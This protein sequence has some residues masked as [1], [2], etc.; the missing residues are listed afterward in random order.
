MQIIMPKEE[1]STADLQKEIKTEGDALMQQ[2]QGVK[3]DLQPYDSAA[4][5]QARLNSVTEQYGDI[6]TSV[7]S[8][9]SEGFVTMF[10]DILSGNKQASKSFKEV[11]KIFVET[12][13][14]FIAASLAQAVAAA[15]LKAM[16][17]GGNPIASLII[18]GIAS[19]GVLALFSAIPSFATGG[20]DSS[21]MFIAGESQ[22][23]GELVVNTGQGS[24]I[25]NHSQTKSMMKQGQQPIVLSAR[26]SGDSLYLVNEENARRR[27]NT[28]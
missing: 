25:Y 3:I 2:G 13:K 23:R 10:S 26:I 6:V 20:F 21:G 12:A 8:I 5:A 9:A 27:A 4:E 28:I 18:A 16:A 19:A 7:S 11:G 17:T 1:K 14:Q 15:I 22:G 24:R